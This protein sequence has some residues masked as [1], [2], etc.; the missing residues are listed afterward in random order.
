MKK[1]YFLIILSLFISPI[2]RAINTTIKN[3]TDGQIKVRIE[4]EHPD[5][6]APEEFLVETEKESLHPLSCKLSRIIITA[7]SGKA[8]RK[9]SI[10]IKPHAWFLYPY[11]RAIKINPDFYTV[12]ISNQVDGSLIS[13]Q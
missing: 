10:T 2:T 9:E 11:E 3:R 7:T 5:F 6:C 1:I 12:I 4:Y 13:N 8:F